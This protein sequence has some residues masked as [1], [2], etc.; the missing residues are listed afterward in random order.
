MKNQKI[1]T[2]IVEIERNR[3]GRVIKL[4]K[5]KYPKFFI[6]IMISVISYFVFSNDVVVDFFKSLHGMGYIYVFFFGCLFAFGFSTPIATGFFVTF[7]PS[8]IFLTALIG[9]LGAM[10]SDLLIF[11]FVKI[12]FT[13]EFE[14][15]KKEKIFLKF[16]ELFQVKWIMK[17]EKYLVFIFAGIVIASP[18]PD[19]IGIIMLAGFDQIDVKTLGILSFIFKMAGI[20]VLLLI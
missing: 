5:S 13:D 4:F 3:N 8:N 18:M 10:V 6:L 12:S 1:S 9:G 15:L 17:I 19:E 11:K 20:Y 7:S 14:A 2:K 16:R